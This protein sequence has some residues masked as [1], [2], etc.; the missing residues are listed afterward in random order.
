MLFD[1]SEKNLL[2]NESILIKIAYWQNVSLLEL[3]V[4]SGSLLHCVIGEMG[5]QAARI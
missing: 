1:L 4:I 2:L 5:K 3:S